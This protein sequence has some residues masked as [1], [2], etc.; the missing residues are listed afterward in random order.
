MPGLLIACDRHE[1]TDRAADAAAPASAGVI[2]SALPI[3][4]QLKRF[5]ATLRY[6]PESLLH[7]SASPASLVNRW[8]QAVAARDT[9]TLRQLHIDRAEFAELIYEQLRIAKPPYEMAPEL[10]WFQLTS[11]S[12][13][14]VRKVLTKFGGRQL[15]VRGVRCPAPV[16]TQGVLQLRDGCLLRLR[17]DRD[18]LAE[19][20]YFGSIV[21]RDGRFKFLGYSN[22]L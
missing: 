2:D 22:K 14:G 17:V 16:D 3:A 6:R 1:P 7:A 18:A 12:E 13:D 19:E 10:L 5:R 21:N 11:N 20:R 15:T 8:A 9:L 4:E